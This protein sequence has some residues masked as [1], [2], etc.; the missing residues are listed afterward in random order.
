VSVEGPGKRDR[1]V[2][3]FACQERKA[4]IDSVQ[5]ILMFE[6]LLHRPAQELHLIVDRPASTADSEVHLELGALRQG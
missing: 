5:L 3:T 4:L 2:P 1:L 6:E